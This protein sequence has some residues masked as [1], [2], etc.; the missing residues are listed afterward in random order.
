[1]PTKKADIETF[2]AV[3]SGIQNV[4]VGDELELAKVFP[5]ET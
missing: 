3:S 5:A 2:N 1:M 4:D